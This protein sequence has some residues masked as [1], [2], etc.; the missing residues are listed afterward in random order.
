MRDE[1]E[2][3]KTEKTNLEAKI[4][5]RVRQEQEIKDKAEN[6]DNEIERLETLLRG[7]YQK[8]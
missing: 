4:K 1:T 3:L 8:L 6:L 2:E 7:E 5:N